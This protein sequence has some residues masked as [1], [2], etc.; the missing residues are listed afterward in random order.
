MESFADFRQWAPGKLLLQE[1]QQR[2]ADERQIREE[3]GV[4]GTR[5]V[6]AHEGVASPVIADFNSAPMA[7]NQSQPLL[8][9]VGLGRRTGK[10][11][12]G[13]NRGHAGLFDGAFAAQ[14]D[15]GAG[16]GEFGAEGFD[17]KGMESAHF[18]PSVAELG[19]GKKGVSFRAF[20][21]RACWS[22]LGWLP[23]I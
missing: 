17:G 5:A 7:A 23:L 15:Q 13:F 9:M 4:A 12:T 3:I 6:F 22:N 18:N 20:R 16:K 19:V 8:R 2:A 10:I 11:E 14:H 1:V 21:R